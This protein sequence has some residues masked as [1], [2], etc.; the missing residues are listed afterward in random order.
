[1]EGVQRYYQVRIR[2]PNSWAGY[3]F[4][5]LVC[6][7]VEEAAAERDRIMSRPGMNA[8]EYSIWKLEYATEVSVCGVVHE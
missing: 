7:T 3:E 6:H 8:F 5:G 1:M 2:L 4:I